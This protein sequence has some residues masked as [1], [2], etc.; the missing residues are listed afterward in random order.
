MINRRALV[1]PELRFYNLRLRAWSQPVYVPGR[2]RHS[3]VLVPSSSHQPKLMVVGGRDI[4]G[5]LSKETLII[6]VRAAFQSLKY[7]LPPSHKPP[8]EDYGQGVYW[9]WLAGVV[10]P[11]G[12]YYGNCHVVSHGDSLVIF[13]LL[14]RAASQTHTQ[15][16]SV[17]H[18]SSRSSGSRTESRIRLPEQIPPPYR[19]DTNPTHSG[20]ALSFS[21]GSV[22][23]RELRKV[24]RVAQKAEVAAQSIAALALQ[25]QTQSSLE[26]L[27]PPVAP[28]L[29][30]QPPTPA[31]APSGPVPPKSWLWC[32]V[33]NS[34]WG[35]ATSGEEDLLLMMY[36]AEGRIFL[37][38]VLLSALGLLRSR[39][40]NNGGNT[41]TLGI[42]L[43][44]LLPQLWDGSPQAPSTSYMSPTIPPFADFLLHT[45]TPGAPPLAVHRS[46]L[47]SCSAYFKTLL[48]SGFN[49]SRTGEASV[50]E[51]FARTSDCAR[52]SRTC[53][54]V[55]KVS[56]AFVWNHVD[57]G[58]HL[59]SLLGGTRIIDIQKTT[60]LRKIAI[61][62]ASSS[63]VDFSRFDIYAPYVRR[64]NVYGPGPVGHYYQVDGWDHL[65]VRAQQKPLLPNLLSIILQSSCDEHGPDQLVW[66]KTFICPSLIN[67]Q[68]T[69]H[70]VSSPPCISPLMA[71]V[72]LDAV[73]ER[74]PRLF[75]LS[76]F[77]SRTLKYEE[78]NL[79][80]YLRRRPYYE[81]LRALPTLV[82]LTCSTMM[83][84][85][86][87]LRIVSSL[88]QLHRLIILTSGT[89][90]V[91]RP[92]ELPRESFPALQQLHIKGLSPYEVITILSIPTLMS[93]LIHLELKFQLDQ[94]DEDEDRDEWIASELLSLLR[95]SPQLS[96]LDLDLDPIR[97][98]DDPY[99][100]GHQDLMD[101]FSKLPL[102][103][104]ALGGVHLGDWAYTGSLKSVWP[105]VTILRM[106]D[107][108]AS[109]R[110]LSCFAQ[111]PRVQYL[112][113]NVY[114]E[115]FRE[116]PKVVSLCPLQTLEC[117]PG[118][119]T[120]CEPEQLDYTGRFLLALFPNLRKIVWPEDKT[121]ELP[122]TVAHQRFIGFLNQH[123]TLKRELEQLKTKFG[124]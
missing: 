86:D 96:S 61:G 107:Q 118:G 78:N 28:A 108:F 47:L 17:G 8:A 66:I 31:P 117:S 71:D 120:V 106:R 9:S 12:P 93:G 40:G 13:A 91:L 14:D 100:I 36:Q 39:S 89:T 84:E 21:G 49:E 53:K 112:M 18:R 56:T 77:P 60:G 73:A 95:L 57:G 81:S 87:S 1:L 116:W 76:L 54:T 42:G 67:I 16:I 20:W 94:L 99:D 123:I 41:S 55:F 103:N 62:I 4:R 70:S 43:A 113:L 24:R 124:V 29:H 74:C 51:G 2:Y 15:P 37:V 46:I 44:G 10:Q 98:Q 35:T 114:L 101:T 25:A 119:S 88:P 63:H 65:I 82:E 79:L 6:D 121:N 68:A 110:I 26:P 32:G 19:H 3:A 115:D 109:P 22:S 11:L 102:V 23:F 80:G 122:E 33:V 7:S 45:S 48:S 50:D 105:N 58:Q 64:L 38:P 27:K 5:N 85:S 52:L 30:P 75:R 92:P 34:G 104:V 59:L 111:L 69:P 97:V 83:L 90:V 72:I